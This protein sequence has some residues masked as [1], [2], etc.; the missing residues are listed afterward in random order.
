MVIQAVVAVCGIC[1]GSQTPTVSSPDALI[2]KVPALRV[3]CKKCGEL[4]FV[5]IHG[6][7]TK[8]ECH[9]CGYMLQRQSG[10]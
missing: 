5:P 2:V 3:E 8:P 9:A 7:A 1:A 10:G 6:G 4:N